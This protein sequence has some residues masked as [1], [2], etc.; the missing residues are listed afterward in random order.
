LGLIGFV[1]GLTGVMLPGPMLVCVVT[2]VLRGKATDAIPIVLGYVLV[3]TTIITLILFGLKKIISSRVLFDILAIVGGGALILMGF[4]ILIGSSQINLPL[5]KN[6]NFLGGLIMGRI[7]F[8]AFNFTFSTWWVSIGAFLLYRVLL[9]GLSGVLMLTLGHWLADFLWFSL[10][11]VTVA[12]GKPWLNDRRHGF[13][14]KALTIAM[15]G[16]GSGFIYQI[17]YLR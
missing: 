2:K 6:A 8:T 12:K 3:E 5:N 7:F 4:H 16:I 15:V 13:V 9:F 10:V 14:L 11:G 17:S 1:V